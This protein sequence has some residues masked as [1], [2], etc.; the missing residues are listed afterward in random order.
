MLVRA[1]RTGPADPR[2]AREV[3]DL[4]KEK[5]L[6]AAVLA[7]RAVNAAYCLFRRKA[8]VR[9]V[10]RIL[11]VKLDAIGDVVLASPF[12]RELRTSFPPASITMIVSPATAPLLELCPYIDRLL[13]FDPAKLSQ[14]GPERGRLHAW[15]FGMRLYRFRFDLAILPRWDR[16][17]Y[18]GYYLLCGSG[19]SRIVAFTRT[20]A[21]ARDTWISRIE[22]RDATILC[23]DAPEHEVTRN[24][25]L[26]EAAGGHAH[27]DTLE[28]WMSSQDR[29]LAAA[30]FASLGR[31][32]ARYKF[33]FGIGASSRVR[34]WPAEKFGE[35]GGLLAAQFDADIILIGTGSE[36][37]RRA[38]SIIS[39][40]HHS[41][42]VSAVGALS[43]R[44]SAAFLARCD[45]FVG[46]DSGPMH[47]AS[48]V[49][50][51]IVEICG[52][53]EHVGGN[54]PSSPVR[55][56]PRGPH[57]RIV[58]P[59][60]PVGAR[61]VADGQAAALV[62]EAVSVAAVYGAVCELVADLPTSGRLQAAVRGT[63]E[64]ER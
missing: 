53:P 28:L 44:Q 34:C 2:F 50:V 48:A 20:M 62:P 63:S 31:S 23:A 15:A 59:V 42:I 43:L 7:L 52:L 47:L 35:L 40:T 4:E 8:R 12:L 9:R 14:G 6:L 22:R 56:G 37:R 39:N 51:P 27:S 36:D 46:N 33:A 38:E 54:H 1:L 21:A 55:F 5:A 49:G 57:T 16:D 60:A 19:A 17:Y 29:D 41:C 26:L 11:V 58:R 64:F 18:Y 13:T 24:L 3:V 30:W 45:I 10:R 32:E 61:A 25:R